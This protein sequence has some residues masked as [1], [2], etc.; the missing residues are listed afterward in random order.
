M[1]TIIMNSESKH[2]ISMLWTKTIARQEGSKLTIQKNNNVNLGMGYHKKR[3]CEQILKNL[4]LVTQSH[5]FVWYLCRLW[6]H[7]LRLNLK[8]WRRQKK[9]AETYRCE[10]CMEQTLLEMTSIIQSHVVPWKRKENF[11]FF[12][13]ETLIKI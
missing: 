3:V 12:F 7:Q 13:H 1:Y 8:S 4:I 5:H 9:K 10:R 6:V 11:L 2:T